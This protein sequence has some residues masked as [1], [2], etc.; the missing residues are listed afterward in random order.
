VP[1]V[2]QIKYQSYILEQTQK[3]RGGKGIRFNCVKRVICNNCVDTFLVFVD[4]YPTS[5]I[6]GARSV[7]VSRRQFKWRQKVFT[8]VRNHFSTGTVFVMAL[9]ATVRASIDVVV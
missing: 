4:C 3:L 1:D 2:C 9:T 8:Q 6:I 7:S 5:K